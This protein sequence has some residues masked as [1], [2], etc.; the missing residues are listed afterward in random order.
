MKKCRACGKRFDVIYPELWRYKD[1]KDTRVAKKWYC[2]WKCLRE[3][4]K[5]EEEKK[6][7]RKMA[8]PRKN[9]APAEEKQ[10]EVELVYDESIREEYRKE[11]EEEAA[12]GHKDGALEVA[13]V[14]SRVL[15]NHTY[16]KTQDGMALVGAGT[17]L[18]LNDYEWARFAGEIMQAKRQLEGE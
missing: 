2:S 17:T 18:V 7:E 10:T 3:D 6:G 13:A 11:Q 14:F 12:G 16:K 5:R 8:R 15:T 9:A 1:A 4:E